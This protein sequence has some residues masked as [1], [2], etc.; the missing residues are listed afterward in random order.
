MNIKPE[1]KCLL[2]GETGVGKSTQTKGLANYFMCAT[3]EETKP[4]RRFP[5]P[6]FFT[7]TDENEQLVARNIEIC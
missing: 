6:V 4:G 5:I 3:F 1:L 7:I 2:L